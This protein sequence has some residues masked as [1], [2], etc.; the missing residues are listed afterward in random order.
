MTIT[1]TDVNE[2]PDFS[3]GSQIV[4][5]PENSTDLWGPAVDDYSVNLEGGVTYTAMDPGG[6]HCQLFA[7]GTG[8]VQVPAQRLT[9]YPVLRVEAR[10]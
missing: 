7:G 8:C 5:V 4:S 3:T 10:L 1:I 2:E 9:P 6:T